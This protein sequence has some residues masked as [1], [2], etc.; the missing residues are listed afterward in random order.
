MK[1]GDLFIEVTDRGNEV[2][3]L[4]C[5]TIDV[6]FASEIVLKDEFEDQM[7]LLQDFGIDGEESEEHDVL[8][9]PLI[10][11]KRAGQEKTEDL[12]QT[13]FC[14]IKDT[15]V[16]TKAEE[17]QLAKRLEKS[18]QII[19]GIITNMPLYKKVESALEVQEEEKDEKADKALDLSLKALEDLMEK[20]ESAGKSTEGY[21]ETNCAGRSINEKKNGNGAARLMSIKK[22]IEEKRRLVETEVGMRIEDFKYLWSRIRRETAVIADAR[23][24]LI[25]RNLRL[26][27]HMAKH[28][29]GKGLPL[30]DLIQEGN[31]GLM[32]AVD[33]FNYEKGCKFSTYAKWWIKQA[34]A[35]AVINQAKTIRVP[36]H[37]MDY[38]RT[39][40]QTSR[41]L[42][43]RLGREPEHEEIAREL[44]I[45]SKKVE[46]HFKVIQKT[47]SLQSGIGDEDS[48]LEDFI[49]DRST[50]TP[51]AC[52]EEKEISE[53][54]SKIL[55]TL[56]RREEK[57]IRMRFG[58]GV[59][60][61]YT[62]EE[63][64]KQFFITREGVRQLEV[65][66]LRRLRHPSRQMLFK[67]LI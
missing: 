64:G 24:E 62:L 41:E 28:Y 57:I 25:T 1:N 31:I 49:E 46:E 13:Y 40:N 12:V 39:L 59:K 29:L 14:S 5:D 20:I 53:N 58:I 61:D 54:I 21:G 10:E 3:L 50:P 45:T 51:E 56:T 27:I 37:V 15:S 48:K 44:G 47:V 19:K 30:L 65:K 23:N 52:F 34:I 22:E 36:I 18:R 4:P 33:R 42:T 32:K 55:K 9:E 8:E 38:Y 11:D 16:L 60:K 6:T 7:D 67:A 2:G 17:T 35:R 63:I 43:Q 26:V 66:A